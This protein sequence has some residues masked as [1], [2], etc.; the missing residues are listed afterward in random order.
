MFDNSNNIL[1]NVFVPPLLSFSR[2]KSS[3]VDCMLVPLHSHHQQTH[4]QKVTKT[5]TKKLA[6]Y[7]DTTQNFVKNPLNNDGH[8]SKNPTGHNDTQFSF[9]ASARIGMKKMDQQLQNNGI[10]N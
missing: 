1:N 9:L 2:K 7:G 6:K 5:S 4:C 3:N 8:P 10:A